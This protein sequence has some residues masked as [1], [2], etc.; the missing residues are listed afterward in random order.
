MVVSCLA[1][2]LFHS[3]FA[4]IFDRP[5]CKYGKAVP[6]HRIKEAYNESRDK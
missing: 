1:N 6:A 5:S 2:L 4:S 3:V